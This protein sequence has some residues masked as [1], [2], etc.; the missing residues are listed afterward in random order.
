MILQGPG[1]SPSHKE[2]ET[3]RD[4]ISPREGELET[5][6]W[7]ER[8][9]SYKKNGDFWET[10]SV[11]H[12]KHRKKKSSRGLVAPS[13][14]DIELVLYMLLRHILHLNSHTNISSLAR[15]YCV[16]TLF[17]YT[18]PFEGLKYCL[19]VTV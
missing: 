5:L 17:L 2:K 6:R 7:E 10:N 8:G 9:K 13:L 15:K 16:L 4:K 3:E 19:H 18:D 14:A 11:R 12:E 1:V